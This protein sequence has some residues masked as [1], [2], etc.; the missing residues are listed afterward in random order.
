MS[1]LTLILASAL[2]AD[3]EDKFKTGE[4][5]GYLKVSEMDT[6]VATAATDHSIAT[7]AT[8][9]GTVPYLKLQ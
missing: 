8:L 2:A 3:W 5:G 7:T 4:L 6:L 9:H 1:I